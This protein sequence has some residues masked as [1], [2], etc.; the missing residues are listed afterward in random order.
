[1]NPKIQTTLAHEVSFSGIG[2]HTGNKTTARFLPAPVNTGIRFI[3]SDLPQAP[4]ILA[5]LSH[6]HGVIRGTTIGLDETRR[7]H[8]VEHILSALY[9]L[10]IDNLRIE[11]TAN[12]PPVADGS[13]LPFVQLFQKAGVREQEASRDILRVTEPILY[14]ADGVV[15]LALPDPALRISCTIDYKHPMLKSQFASFEITPESFCREIAPARTFCFDHEIE[16]LKKSGLA[17]GG[18]MENAIVIGEKNIHTDK[19]R[20]EN[21]FVRHKILDLLGDLY[22][23]GRPLQ[24]H[25]V[26]IRCGHNHNIAFAKR[27]AERLAGSG[28]RAKS[29]PL[30]SKV[31]AG[32][33]LQIHEIQA[34]IP[35]RY[36]FLL[37]DRVLIVEEAKKAIG[38]KAVSGNEPF[39]QGHFPGWPVMPGV[40]IV[41]AM[42]QTGCALF[43]SQPKCQGKLAYF[44]GIS[45][46]KFRKPVLPGDML[47]LEIEVLHARER[48]GRVRG[49]AKVEGQVVAEAEFTF[50]LVDKT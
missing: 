5:D 30:P 12:E 32:R 9:G 11:V 42:A 46:V 8:T 20:F 2:L 7:M 41:E 28:A 29:V 21:E 43:L 17:K 18:N 44:A 35:H 15:L 39:F 23:L 27:L 19:L 6:V 10:G 34:I 47:Q 13:S 1:M 33:L 37:I 16:A 45:D 22:L 36:P 38:F 50:A 25:I 14:N 24:A 48:M 31:P 3:R 26:A 4:E 49:E 40:L